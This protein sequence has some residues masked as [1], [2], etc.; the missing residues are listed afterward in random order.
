MSLT[1]NIITNPIDKLL[2]E[3]WYDPG[4]DWTI[5]AELNKLTR[6]FVSIGLLNAKK[7]I[8]DT[9]RYEQCYYYEWEK[10][11]KIKYLLETML[12]ILENGT[13]VLS[14]QYYR[15]ILTIKKIAEEVQKNEALIDIILGSMIELRHI[16]RNFLRCKF[17]E[18]VKICSI[19]SNYIRFVFDIHHKIKREN[20]IVQQ[21][22]EETKEIIITYSQE[23][24][25][26]YEQYINS[27][28]HINLDLHL[29]LIIFY[30]FIKNLDIECK[31]FDDQ[32]YI[33]V[34]IAKLLQI[35]R[36]PFICCVNAMRCKQQPNA[37]IKNSCIKRVLF[38]KMWMRHIISCI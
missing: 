34:L 21:S 15:A 17:L 32:K 31:A 16:S 19:L 13:N 5:S 38:N 11:D 3:Y 9:T 4:Y 27:I 24:S 26:T 33:K 22:I 30:I 35:Q 29:H 1:I 28:Q 18:S 20:R 23:L 10:N 8:C 25:N 14:I 37:A 6:Y 36:L 12:K 7:I 2:E